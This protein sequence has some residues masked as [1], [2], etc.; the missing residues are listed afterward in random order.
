MP[1]WFDR[2]MDWVNVPIYTRGK[3]ELRRIDI[4]I[5]LAGII[6]VSWYGYTGGWQGAL[7]GAAMYVF[8]AMIALW[9]L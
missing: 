7:M 4:V 2:Y 9:I 1:R 8:V 3:L 6:C 5:A